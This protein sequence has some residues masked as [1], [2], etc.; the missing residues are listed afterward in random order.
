MGKKMET[1]TDFIFLGSKITADGHCS[2]EIKR[3]LLVGQKSY[4]KPRQHIKK[5]QHHFA[6]KGQCNQICG[7]SRSHSRMWEL[8]H[9]DGWVL[10]NWCFQTVVLEKTLESP[11]DSKEIKPVNPKGNQLW[12]FIRRTDAK[13]ELQYFDYLMWGTNS[14]EKILCNPKVYKQ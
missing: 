2:H 11:F 13:P 5:Q 14:L 1:V 10:K 12:I 7:F 6:D 4:D 9:K 8:D 3:C